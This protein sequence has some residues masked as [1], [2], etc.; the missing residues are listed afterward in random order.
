M[1]DL[2]ESRANVIMKIVILVFLFFASLP[3]NQLE[4][5]KINL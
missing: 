5:R 2:I 4:S 3:L 1:V